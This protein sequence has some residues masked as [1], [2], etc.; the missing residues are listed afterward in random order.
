M[1]K[2][3][4]SGAQPNT[5][6]RH[7][8]RR[9]LQESFAREEPVVFSPS[10]VATSFFCLIKDI[11]NDEVVLRNPIKPSLAHA[12]MNSDLYYIFCR[13]FKIEALNFSP[14]GLDLVFSIPESA[15]LSQERTK[16]RTYYSEK[17]DAHVI[18]GHPLDKETEIRRKLIDFSEGGLSF[19]ARKMTSFIQSGRSLPKLKVYCR[20]QLVTERSGTIVY[21]AKIVDS[22][23]E[24]YHQVGVQFTD[25]DT[26]ER[27]QNESASLST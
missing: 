6:N 14:R 15:Q 3:S 26:E 19:R 22:S 27:H 1:Q 2:N 12:V 9:I 25:T 8:I 7:E 13:S 4:E 5:I 24:T 10:G 20:G 23:G 21:A 18:I 11:N 17:D 16:E